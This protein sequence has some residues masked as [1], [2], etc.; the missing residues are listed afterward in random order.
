LFAIQNKKNWY[1]HK[2][3]FS[4]FSSLDLARIV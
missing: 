4:T 1:P 2:Y 3:L